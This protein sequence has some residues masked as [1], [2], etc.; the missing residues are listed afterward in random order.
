M[1]LAWSKAHV[2]ATRPWKV[3]WTFVA[4][5]IVVVSALGGAE[6]ERYLLPVMPLFYIA[7]AAALTT[8]RQFS[9]TAAIAT[10]LAGLLAGLFIN[11]PHPFPYENNLAMVDFVQL[12]RAAAQFVETIYPHQRIYTAWPLTAALR[13]P[14]FGYIGQPLDT[15]E[16]SD[17]HYSTLAAIDPRRVDVLILYSRTW[18]PSWRIVQSTAID[19]FLHK[20]YQYERQMDSAEV[21]GHFGLSMIQRWE[22]R[23]QW[24][25]VYAR[26]GAAKTV[27]STKGN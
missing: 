10:T 8:F 3:I 9:R 26:S 7:A 20:F 19:E 23:G 13:N 5:H 11:P 15:A 22:R 2:Y 1:W 6:L 17:L 14:A 21:G 27:L 16:T 4:A 18:E 12:H 25:E 24:I